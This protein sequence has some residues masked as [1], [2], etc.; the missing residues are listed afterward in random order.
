[1]EEQ[2]AGMDIVSDVLGNENE[3]TEI[4]DFIKLEPEQPKGQLRKF[5]EEW[6][7]FKK[8][9]N[10]GRSKGST[11]KYRANIEKWLNE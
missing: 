7:N 9:V 3:N 8:R 2:E 5:D 4:E 6:I 11:K 1:M 10:D